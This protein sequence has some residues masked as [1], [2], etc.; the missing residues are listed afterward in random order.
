[1]SFWKK[2]FG[3][4]GTAG[5]REVAWRQEKNCPTTR[6]TDIREF[7]WMI[8]QTL[9]LDE[10]GLLDLFAEVYREVNPNLF[11]ALQQAGLWGNIRLKVMAVSAEQLDDPA[12]L[13]KVTQEGDGNTV[14]RQ[15]ATSQLRIGGFI[16][17]LGY[18]MFTV[19]HDHA[20]AGSER[21]VV[22]LDGELL[23]AA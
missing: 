15:G 9:T 19:V 14:F 12:L 6:P 21:Q 17:E 10:S 7:N 23:P 4:S 11:A 8:D 22:L 5:S 18:R 2:L 20:V 16:V 3:G 13:V 1:M